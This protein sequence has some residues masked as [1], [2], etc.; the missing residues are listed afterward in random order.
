M[1]RVD[2]AHLSIDSI[3]ASVSGDSTVT[4]SLHFAPKTYQILGIRD[5]AAIMAGNLK[6]GNQRPKKARVSSIDEGHGDV[7]STCFVYRITFHKQSDVNKVFA[8]FKFE[9]RSVPTVFQKNTNMVIPRTAY[10]DSVARLR[11][12]LSQTDDL[13]SAWNFGDLP[14]DLRFQ[15]EK[16]ATNGKLPHTAVLQLLHSCRDIHDRFGIAAASDAV[17]QLYKRIPIPGPHVPANE[18]EL[19][20]LRA[21][22]LRNA[23]AYRDKGSYFDI[24]RRHQNVVLVY[25]ARVTPAGIYFYGPEPESSNRVL[26]IHANHRD[27][28]IRTTFSDE[29]GLP[30]MFDRSIDLSHIYQERFQGIMN[31]AINAADHSYRF[32]GYSHSSLRS[33][34]V[35][36]MSTIAPDK[37][38]PNPNDFHFPERV[39]RDL[40]DFTSFRSPAKCAARIGQ[41]FSDTVGS[42]FLQPSAIA[43]IKD[44]E[45]NE[46]VFSDGCGTI[47]L[48][49]LR[50]V[51]KSYRVPR[52]INPVALQIRFQ[53]AKGMLSVDTRLADD[54]I[55]IRPSM[56]KFEARNAQ[57]LEI[58]G[59]AYK[60]LPAYLN[61][62]FTKILEDLGV[63]EEVFM[64]LQRRALDFLEKTATGAINMASFLRRRRLCESVNLGSYLT[65]LQEI[66]LSFQNDSFLTTC[67]ELALLTDLNDMK[68]RGRIPLENAVTLYGIMDE[69]GIIPEGYIYVNVER[70]DGRGNP[71]RETLS[72]GQV[73]ITRAPAMFPGDV[74]IVRTMDVPAGHPLDSLY[75]VVVF[76]QHGAR[77]LPSMLSGGDLDGDIFTVIYDKGL[78]PPRQYPPADFPKVEAIDIG[79]KV[80]ARDITEFAVGFWENDILGKIAFE[81]MYLAD[82]KKAGTLDP[83]CQKMAALASIAVDYSKT[84][85][86][87]DPNSLPDFDRRFRPHFM[88]PEPRLL[89][90][91]NSEDGPVFTYEG[92]EAQEDALKLLD[93]DKKGYQYYQSHRVLGKLFDEIDEMKF[94]SRVKEAAK[95]CNENPMTEEEMFTRLEKHILQ[96]S[97]GI[98]WA[99]EM[100]LA[101]SIKNTY[102]S[103]V[104]D[105]MLSF[106]LHPALPLREPE[107]FTGTILGRSAGASN[108]RLRETTKDMRER[109]ERDCLDT[110]YSIRYGRLY[111]DR[112]Y[113]DGNESQEEEGKETWRADAEG[114]LARSIAAFTVAVQEEGR[115]VWGVEDRLRSFA[116]VAT[117][118]CLRQLK[119]VQGAYYESLIA[120]L[121]TLGIFGNELRM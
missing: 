102:E 67:T 84:G 119:G 20:T 86:K 51:W 105:T 101:K 83:I 54:M 107:V 6:S 118:E 75:N 79:R 8:W 117:A 56:W 29:E 87:V 37:N 59:A 73:V 103:N 55:C 85:Q 90:N 96:Q 14:F 116:H 106:A 78:L 47:S 58:C 62:Q 99:Q 9:R 104:E 98:Q 4:F 81:H 45:R 27:A 112:D 31:G 111:V 115:K 108:K 2:I 89:L 17:R 53:G 95:K 69:T 18:L 74:R 93:P 41:T 60:P 50:K 82:A 92:T 52:A 88:A 63:P 34:T 68:Y 76:S 120:R 66:G 13:G 57:E 26:R 61:R 121:E 109:F 100:E 32:L 72:D 42:V 114:G 36:F 10:Y 22:L 5:I 15:L 21:T 7:V 71:Y 11:R 65:N 44:I 1:V 91:T 28:F 33:Q 46:R 97:A 80:T 48:Q 39:L 64:T 38:S 43:K 3:V 113:N 40:G 16:L 23:A 30:L 94:F 70:L 77:D 110:V 25:R 49:L 19:D 24:A 35:W 12:A